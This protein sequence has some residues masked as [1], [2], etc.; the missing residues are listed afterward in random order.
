MVTNHFEL[1]SPRPDMTWAYVRFPLVSHIPV[2]HVYKLEISFGS[3]TEI[4]APFL[5]R[6]LLVVFIV[7][8]PL[9]VDFLVLS[10]CSNN[11]SSIL[12]TVWFSHV[13]ELRPS[14]LQ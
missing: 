8:E 14:F 7:P 1:P 11:S 5:S 9:V 6:L 3:I 2:A 10:P 12:P 13:D 4:R